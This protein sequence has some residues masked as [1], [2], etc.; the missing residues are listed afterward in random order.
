VGSTKTSLAAADLFGTGFDWDAT[1]KKLNLDD[2][3]GG[4]LKVVSYDNVA[5]TADVVIDASTMWNA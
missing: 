1:N 5:D 2:T 4:F 3:T